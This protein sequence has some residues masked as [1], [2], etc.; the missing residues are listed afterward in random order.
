M[1]DAW[2]GV[3]YPTDAF[4]ARNPNGV[5]L[6]R[7]G[8]ED[9]ALRMFY[10]TKPADSVSTNPADTGFFGILD[11]PTAVRFNLP[12]A[13]LTNG[14][15]K[16]VVTPTIESIHAGYK[17]MTTARVSRAG[18]RPSS[19]QACPWPRST[20]RSFQAHRRDQGE[21]HPELLA[22]AVGP[23]QRTLPAGFLPFPAPL[24][25][26]TAATASSLTMPNPPAP[27]TTG[28]GS[29]RTTT[30]TFPTG[31]GPTDTPFVSSSLT[32]SYYPAPLSGPTGTDTPGG[33]PDR[34]RRRCGPSAPVRT[35]RYRSRRRSSCWLGKQRA[36]LAMPIVSRPRP[37][38]VRL[39]STRAISLSAHAGPL[40][41]SHVGC[42]SSRP[43]IRRATR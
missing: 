39:R 41:R 15:G 11:L 5:Y 42:S 13:R 34:R 40:L 38:Y 29:T 7:T 3:K 31:S 12:I 9:I 37:A 27:P 8:E 26:Q 19:P 24:V 30:T 23:G 1:N 32:S 16:P 6:P 25:A 10:S 28:P 35:P 18:R 14:V 33:V 20:T 4:E 17:A 22:Y 36:M 21:E 43:D 2:K